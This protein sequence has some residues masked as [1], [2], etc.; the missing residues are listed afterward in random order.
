M[1]FISFWVP[2]FMVHLVVLNADSCHTF[3]FRNVKTGPLRAQSLNFFGLFSAAYGS[4]N[5]SG[6]R[7]SLT[8]PM[9]TG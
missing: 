7:S 9:T 1:L 3:T 6:V 8:A 2:F 4:R 5:E